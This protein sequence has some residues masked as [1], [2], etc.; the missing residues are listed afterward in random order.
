MQDSGP[1][2]ITSA[3]PGITLGGE[4]TMKRTLIPL[5]ALFVAASLVAATEK[6]ATTQTTTAA[7][8]SPLV[9][10]AK[11]TNKLNGKKRIVITDESIKTSKG[12]I[13]TTKFQSNFNVAEP[14]RSTEQVL[15][16]TKVKENERAAERAKLQKAAD[17]KKQ[18]QIARA[19]A[20]AEDDGPYEVDPAAVEHQLDQ[21]TSTAATATSSQPQPSKHD[22]PQ[23]P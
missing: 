6:P 13:S 7:P 17:E 21:Q 9:A 8:D 19:V 3:G 14:Q 15:Y 5:A 18:K 23:R 22:D 11:K 4:T 2:E 12:H 10:A 1:L 16:E 20:A